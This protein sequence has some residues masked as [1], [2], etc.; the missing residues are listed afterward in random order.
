MIKLLKSKDSVSP[1]A[2][3]LV[4]SEIVEKLKELLSSATCSSSVNQCEIEGRLGLFEDGKN[5][6]GVSKEWFES[7]LLHF[8]AP[9]VHWDRTEEETTTAYLYGDGL[10]AIQKA[11]NTTTFIFKNRR[12]KID[13]QLEGAALQ[14]RFAHALEIPMEPPCATFKW[15]R[16]RKRKSFYRGPFRFDFSY[17]L[18][19]KSLKHAGEQPMKYEIEIEFLPASLR[20]CIDRGEHVDFQYYALA[21]LMLMH[22]LVTENGHN[23]A[24]SQLK[25]SILRKQ[26]F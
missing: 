10:R 25:A 7:K 17:I 6:V 21:F 22:D 26:K 18:E 1:Y 13:V 16:L 12:S 9:G 5:E 20:E 4:W 14:I 8:C 19:E 24:E 3:P 2:V 11:D 23:A 15:V